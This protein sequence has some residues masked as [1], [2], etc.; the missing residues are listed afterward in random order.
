MVTR[1]PAGL[2]PAEWLARDGVSGLSAFDPDSSPA[3]DP[4]PFP[5]GRE[6]VSLALTS[7][8][9]PVRDTIAAVVPVAIGLPPTQLKD[10][11]GQVVMEMTTRGL[12]PNDGFGPVL[13]QAILTEG[14][15][16]R[17]QVTRMP[18]SLGPTPT[19]PAEAGHAA[20]RGGLS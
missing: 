19:L 16:L 9:D 4:R 2:D 20:Y 11:I 5:P 14:A 15:A 6:L 8:Q 1:L 10:L 12:N 13:R 17:D 18:G 3:Q 7:A